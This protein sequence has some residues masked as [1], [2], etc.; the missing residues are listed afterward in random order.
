MFMSSRAESGRY[1]QYVRKRLQIKL[2]HTRV[3]GPLNFNSIY[4]LCD[5][6]EY[7]M[8]NYAGG[9]Y[10]NTLRDLHTVITDVPS[11]INASCLINAPLPPLLF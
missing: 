3:D 7:D 8:K 5:E 11:Q 2:K 6:A 4:N 9:C 1:R 10:H